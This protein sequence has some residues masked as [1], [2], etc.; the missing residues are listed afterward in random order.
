MTRVL[1]VF[2]LSCSLVLTGC[3]NL[4]SQ[5][6][7]RVDWPVELAEPATLIDRL[8][9]DVISYVR[10][11][12]PSAWITAPKNNEMGDL[13]ATDANRAAITTLLEALRQRLAP[14]GADGA[15]AGLLL[16]RL[17]SPL[18]LAVRLP[19]D[20]ALTGAELQV[21]ARLDFETRLAFEQQLGRLL[22]EAPLVRQLVPATADAPGRLSLGV[23][24]AYYQFDPQ[25]RRFTMSAGFGSSAQTLAQLGEVAN[26]GHPAVKRQSE[27]EDSRYGVYL[28]ANTGAVVH[29]LEPLLPAAQ[30]RELD[31]LGIMGSEEV[32]MSM[33]SRAGRGQT[34]LLLRGTDGPLWDLALPD[35]PATRVQSLGEP[36]YYV[37]SVI[38]DEDWVRRLAS[39][40]DWTVRDLNQL[41][42][43]TGLS[44][45]TFMAGLTGRFSV[46]ADDAGS[47]LALEPTDADAFASLLDELRFRGYTETAS[48]ST[49]NGPMNRLL[50]PLSTLWLDQQMPQASDWLMR[51]QDS[52]SWYYEQAGIWYF[53]TVPQV[54]LARQQTAPDVG[55]A[56]WSQQ[57]IDRPTLQVTGQFESLIQTNYHYYLEGLQTLAHMLDT[58]IDLLA[59]PVARVAQLPERS[60]ASLSLTY[61]E[62]TFKAVY[63]YETHPFDPLQGSMGGVAFIG[64]LAAIAIPAYQDYRQE[65][66]QQTA[67]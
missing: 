67:L 37:T 15:M 20:T 8:D 61:R 64:I 65:V 48:F 35:T 19:G 36:R 21:S 52:Q 44:W 49:A 55:L 66:S 32:A 63:G 51:S 30:A 5:P 22:E 1:C 43:R 18:E 33:G 59:F 39:V 56:S 9:P 10:L 29:Q 24:P 54:L 17:R 40:S 31:S 46:I 2:I 42:T 62:S 53:A 47:Y 25:T 60:Q 38:P 7:T 41:T 23:L 50:L 16:D 14:L 11:P 13:L 3:S 4:D 58:D 27:L 12:S 57:E 45:T 6:D 28:W 34:T 26:P